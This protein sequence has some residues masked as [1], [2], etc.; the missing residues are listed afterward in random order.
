MLQE[1]KVKNKY[2]SLQNLLFGTYF[3]ENNI[4]FI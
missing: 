2:I 3:I 4:N 1:Q